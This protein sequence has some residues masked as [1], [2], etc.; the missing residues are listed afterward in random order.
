M[1][2]TVRWDNEEK[3]IVRWDFDGRWTADDLYEA[4]ARTL[5]L[6]GNVDHTVYGLG[7]V[8][9]PAPV[10]VSTINEQ[11]M[12]PWPAN[13]HHFVFVGAGGLIESAF[14]LLARTSP[15]PPRMLFV[16]TCTEAY[17]IIT[18]LHLKEVY[19]GS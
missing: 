14:S 7:V 2:I 8:Q 9:R 3:T 1:G 5:A 18:Q 6:A 19:V 16:A 10:K 13:M 12:G 15:L 11:L 17:E 4:H